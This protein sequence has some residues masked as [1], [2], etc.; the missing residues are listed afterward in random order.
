MTDIQQSKHLLDLSKH[1][2][3]AMYIYIG[4]NFKIIN[5]L[6]YSL[7]M[8]LALML[9]TLMD[10]I[11]DVVINTLI[12]ISA[13]FHALRQGLL[14]WQEGLLNTKSVSFQYVYKR[15]YP[16]MMAMLQEQRLTVCC[17]RNVK[18]MA[19]DLCVEFICASLFWNKM[20]LLD[21]GPD[22]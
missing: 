4:I 22:L 1:S 11:P 19:F 17:W 20:V 16:F 10:Q 5:M 9:S 7:T 12:V 6:L 18:L 14:P 2:F 3:G 21:K 13:H 8:E 15:S